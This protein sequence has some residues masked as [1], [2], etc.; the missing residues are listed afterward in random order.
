ML[1]RLRRR[2][3]IDPADRTPD[4][5]DAGV[6]G[7]DTLAAMRDRQRE[8]FGGLA[9]GSA[10]FGWLCAAAITAIL[11]GIVTGAGVALGLT[12]PEAGEGATE[13]SIETIGFG[14]G[15]LLLLILF[16]AYYAGGYVAGRMAR[17]DGARQGFGVWA[18]GILVAV[19]IAVVAVIGGAEYNVLDRFDVPRIPVDQ[20]DLTTGGAIAL[21]LGL[22]VTLI[23]AVVGGKAGERYHRA[24]DREALA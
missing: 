23:A 10:F 5:R 1:E 20:G 24:V 14:G 4:P 22:A 18:W 16:L 15:V 11:A 9:W 12:D 21:L 3:D 2:S 8:A 6:V 7:T 19:A 13:T 17:F